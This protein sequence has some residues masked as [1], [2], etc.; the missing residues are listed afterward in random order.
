MNIGLVPILGPQLGPDAEVTFKDNQMTF[1]GTS[2]TYRIDAGKDPMQLDWTVRGAVGHWIFKLDGDEL[3]LAVM[4]GLD[5]PADFSPQ[6]G[7]NVSVF[8]RR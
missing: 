3:T 4:Q 6:Q 8:K 1:M 5:R 7:K 2:G